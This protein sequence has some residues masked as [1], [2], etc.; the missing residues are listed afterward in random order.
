MFSHSASVCLGFSNSHRWDEGK[1]LKRLHCTQMVV[2]GVI[3]WT[4]KIQVL[5]SSSWNLNSESNPHQGR[6][7]RDIKGF[8]SFTAH[9]GF[10]GFITIGIEGFVIFLV[11]F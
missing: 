10:N 7:C 5:D 9:A 8:D 6:K 11:I 3:H 4:E 2:E 1:Y